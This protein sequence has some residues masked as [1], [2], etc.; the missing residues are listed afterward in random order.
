M[1]PEVAHQRLLSLILPQGVQTILLNIE[2]I[3]VEIFE[4]FP[5]EAFDL[6][7]DEVISENRV[8]CQQHKCYDCVRV[9]EEYSLDD[10]VD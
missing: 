5:S 4:H 8:D 2:N 10:D 9:V 6:K 3:S 1:K 7:S